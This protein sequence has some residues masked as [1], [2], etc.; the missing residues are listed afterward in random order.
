MRPIRQTDN[1]VGFS[2]RSVLDPD[3]A[4]LLSNEG[5][6]GMC[7]R[8]TFA[9]SWCEQGSVLCTLQGWRTQYHK[10]VMRSICAARG[11]WGWR[12]PISKTS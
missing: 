3:D 12:E 10:L 4:Q 6:V 11:I 5:M 9:T 1:D 7:D 8:H 2:G